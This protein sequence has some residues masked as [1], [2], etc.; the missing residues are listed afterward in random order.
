MKLSDKIYYTGHSL[1]L[2]LTI[3]CFS[4]GVIINFDLLIIISFGILS[5]WL[6]ILCIWVII[7]LWK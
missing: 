1:A 3:I 2:L 5:T 4:I 7:E 6:I